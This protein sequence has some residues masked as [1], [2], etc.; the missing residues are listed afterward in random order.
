MLGVWPGG[1]QAHTCEG[2]RLG[3]WLGGC[4]GPHP[5]GSRSTPRWGVQ[6]QAQ[7]GGVSQHGEADP[8]QQMAT[9]AGGVHPTGM[10]SC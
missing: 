8:P 6:V 4:P 3:V 9:A 5:G 7:K 10:H 2:G 1:P